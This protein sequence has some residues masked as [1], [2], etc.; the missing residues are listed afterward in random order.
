MKHDR[1]IDD[2]QLRHAVITMNFKILGLVLGFL[3]G[4]IVFLATNWL[5]LKGGATS[6]S[7]ILPVGPHLQLLNQFF[8]GYSVTFVGSIVGFLYGFALG[9]L[10]GAALSFIYNKLITLRGV[11][12]IRRD[13]H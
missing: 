11:R 10:T 4:L 6:S 3:F 12:S 5:L 9:S 2:V 8:I 1:T 7:E 13:S